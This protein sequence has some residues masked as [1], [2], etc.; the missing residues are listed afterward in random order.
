MSGDP[1]PGVYI[2]G[3]VDATFDAQVDD[4]GLGAVRTI[5]AGDVAA[6]CS[7]VEGE[8]LGRRRE[9][10]AHADVLSAACHESAVV[11]FT[12]GTVLADDDAVRADLLRPHAEHLTQE[13]DRLREVVQ[14]NLRLVADEQRVLSDVLAADAGLARL[15]EQVRRLPAGVGQAERLR[16]GEAAARAFQDACARIGERV[17]DAVGRHTEETQVEYVGSQDGGTSAA[18]LVRRD[19][20]TALLQE[21]D[22]LA[23]SLHGRVTFRLV[24]PLPPF[25]FVRPLPTEDRETAWA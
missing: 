16:L 11:P 21:V 17:L 8:L 10:K 14:F 22:R 25:A 13:L 4:G 5:P 15:N 18:L 7:D 24:G 2:Y 23:G 9:L 6:L 3:V 20:T 12:F 1:L 19:Q